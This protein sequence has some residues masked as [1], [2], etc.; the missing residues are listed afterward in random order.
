MKV[1]VILIVFGTLATVFKDLWWEKNKQKEL[2]IWEKK[3]ES[4]Q[5]TLLLRSAKKS[6]RVLNTRGDFPSPRLQKERR[7]AYSGVKTT[8]YQENG[9]PDKRKNFP[10]PVSVAKISSKG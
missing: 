3:N 6:R 5:T 2:E 7:L 1:M 9:T 4:I 10:E 8:A